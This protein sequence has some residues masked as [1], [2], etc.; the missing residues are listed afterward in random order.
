MSQLVLRAPFRHRAGHTYVV[1][2]RCPTVDWLRAYCAASASPLTAETLAA[3]TVSHPDLLIHPQGVSVN[4]HT[5]S[6]GATPLHGAAVEGQLEVIEYLISR[7]ADVNAL[8]AYGDSPMENARSM[9][10]PEA[11]HLLERHGG[12]V[13]R[14]TDEQRNRAIEEEVARDMRRVD[15]QP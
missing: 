15:A 14:G 9:N 10:H 12:R 8:N 2:R 5:E 3:L 1:L 6:N 4:V 13:I 11:M 7:G